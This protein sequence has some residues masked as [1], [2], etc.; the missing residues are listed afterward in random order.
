MNDFYDDHEPLR[1][2]PDSLAA[3][4]LLQGVIYSD[5]PQ[6]WDQ[7]LTYRSNLEDYFARIGLALVVDE[8]DGFAYLRQ[9]TDDE[10]DH[11]GG[12]LPRLFRRSSL[13]YDVTLLLVLLRDEM[14]RWEDE[15]LDNGRC[16]VTLDA[17]HEVWKSMQPRT[18]DDVQI[19]RSLDV[20]MKKLETMASCKNSVVKESM[21]CDESSRQ[22]CR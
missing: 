22:D 8:A 21:R 4:R 6:A 19:R 9:W 14:R 10:R 20:A 1:S 12:S 18:M 15:D 16:T 17:L 7:V 2:S 5:D 11:A 3:V 13:S